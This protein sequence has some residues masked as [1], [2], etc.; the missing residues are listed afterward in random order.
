MHI[1]I[2]GA[3]STGCYLGGLMKL[4]GHRVSLIC[5]PRIKQ[6]IESAGGIT[7]TDFTGQHVKVTPDAL[8]TE[9]KDES[10]NCVFVTLKC[11]QLASA[12][13]DLKG[14]A[15]RGSTLFFMQNG[16][17][18]LETIQQQLPPE[19]IKQGITP[20]N[21]LSRENAQFHRGTN[22]SIVLQQTPESAEIKSQLE[23]L[24]FPCELHCDMKPVVYGKLLLNLNNAINAISDL[25]L[26]TQMQDRTL[27]RVLAAA[28][29]EW[30]KVALH[31]Q[32]ELHK[33]TALEPRHLPKALRMPNWI[34]ALF[35]HRVVNVDPLARSSMWEDIQAGRKTEIEFLNGAVV[36]KA[37]ACGLNAPV[38]Q[39]ICEMIGKMESGH[40]VNINAL[41]ALVS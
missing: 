37:Q 1:A 20:F 3:G 13:A 21:V 31:E 34:F 12:E 9:V 27:R 41:L 11:H 5:R 16:L 25:P 35:S 4:C 38:N 18:S 19:R 6:A 30:L 36:R 28:M 7:L 23:H 39:H 10:F 15:E 2:Y 32:V 26:K 29:E 8:I 33:N 22:G 24:G 14:L 17:G 40:E